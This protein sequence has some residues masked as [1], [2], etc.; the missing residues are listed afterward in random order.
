MKFEN[1]ISIH[2][3]SGLTNYILLMKPEL[4]LLSVLT[5]VG[6][7]YLAA[8]EMGN[9]ISLIHTLIGT[10]LVG[11]AAGTLNQYIER[12]YDAQMKRTAQRPLPSGRIDSADAL[13][14]GIVLAIGGI[15]YLALAGNL[16]AGILAALTLA[17]YLCV[18]TPLKRRT[19]FATIVGG[20]PGALP[21]L[22]G[23]AVTRGDLSREAWA[24]FFILFFWQMPHFLALA[25]MYRKD[26]ERAGYKILSVLDPSGKITGRQTLIYS[27]VLI[28]A[29][30]LPTL[31]GMAGIIYFS[32]MLILAFVFLFLSISMYRHHT[33]VSARRLFFASLIF[34]PLLFFFLMISPIL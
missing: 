7:S 9:Y 34:L 19:P 24:L 3:S 2:R 17:S 8:R 30:L 4:T 32:A 29:S 12:D 22:I 20:I 11:G 33:F 6:S 10:L 25:W 21:P 1:A 13:F 16:L 27:I 28:P 26:Y 18:Y 5:A 15:L 23:W 31:L 14:F